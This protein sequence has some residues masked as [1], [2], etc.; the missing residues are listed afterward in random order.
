M[1]L[2]FEIR[3][4]LDCSWEG[5]GR[6]FA[7]LGYCAVASSPNGPT[8]LR[9]A[10]N[11][12]KR[13]LS[14]VLAEKKMKFQII[15]ASDAEGRV[16]LRGPESEA[17]K[18]LPQI[19]K[20]FI[21]S[22][23]DLV[24]YAHLEIVQ[25]GPKEGEWKIFGPKGPAKSESHPTKE[26]KPLAVKEPMFDAEGVDASTY[27]PFLLKNLLDDPEPEVRLEFADFDLLEETLGEDHDLEGNTLGDVMMEVI[28]KKQL[29]KDHEG[30]H[31]GGYFDNCEGSTVLF[32]F[33]TLTDAIRVAEY[34]GKVFTSKKLLKRIY[35]SYGIDLDDGS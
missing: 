13:E 20:C 33:N 14:G 35:K 31:P 3:Q 34:F 17:S 1:E 29:V 18:V 27:A 2:T 28:D 9:Y 7:A 32:H 5:A 26:P 12:L 23:Y 30:T 19:R 21:N 15:G 4:I 16:W 22:S 10:V 25:T 8:N 24:R 6:E 11:T